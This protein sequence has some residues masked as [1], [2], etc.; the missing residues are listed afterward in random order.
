MHNEGEHIC[1]V[2]GATAD[3]LIRVRFP[4]GYVEKL[5]PTRSLNALRSGTTNAIGTPTRAEDR[6]AEH[7]EVAFE[8]QTVLFGVLIPRVRVIKPVETKEAEL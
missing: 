4:R 6:A 8:R 7:R 2:R 3:V 1:K 5:R